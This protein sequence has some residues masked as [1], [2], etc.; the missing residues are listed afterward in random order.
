MIKPTLSQA[1]KFENDY[2]VIPVAME[3]LSD[4]KT[5]MQVLRNIKAK[6]Q[7]LVMLESAKSNDTW[8]RYTFLGFAPKLTVTGKNG[9]VK[10]YQ[11]GKVEKKQGEPVAIL[12]SILKGYTSPQIA[13]LPPF[14]GGFVGYFSYDCIQYF[15]PSL[16]LKASDQ[17]DF[18]DFEM[19]LI[20]KVIAFDHFAQKI[21][22]IVNV[23][24][25]DL[26]N[27]YVNGVATLKDMEQLV[28]S[29]FAEEEKIPQCG[30]FSAMFSKEQYCEMVEK[31][32]HYIHEGDIFQAVP[33]NRMTA[34]FKGSLL[35][36][37]RQ[38]RTINPS[39]YMVYFRFDDMEIAGASPETLVSL[40]N[41]KLS[42]YPLA[43]T[44]PRGKTEEEDNELVQALLQ[45]EKELAE[46]G[47]LVDLGR[48]DLG[49]ISKFGTV[50]VEEYRKIKQFSHVSHVASHVTGKIREDKDALDAIAAALPAGTL[51]GAPK[52]RAC[53]IIDELEGVKRGPYG[54][55]LGYIDFAGNMDMCIGI[56]MA[57]LKNG[58]VFV[59]SGGG[60]V[61]DSV[62]EKEYEET[63][64]KA[65]AMMN[66]LKGE[67]Q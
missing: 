49:K 23:S 60:V 5:S 6:N 11:G 36:V 3:M 54:G 34:E 26:E 59:Q 56:R 64:N 38:L 62:P 10:I 39:P 8:G 33:S 53:E 47:M 25:D 41:G 31:T 32:K 28:L 45:N 35:S 16:H 9:D 55:A 24:T 21:Y 13:N 20:D 7:K 2:Q 46:H 52:K 27:N 61:A 22:L 30:E 40:K 14:T 63:I 1:K 58:K 42:T 44:C 12:R 67:L 15:E 51:S 48:N 37:Y 19:M 29:D 43:G 50:Q 17:E 66:A 4:V 57:V 18:A 65:K